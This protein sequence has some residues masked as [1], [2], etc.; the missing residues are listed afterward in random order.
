MRRPDGVLQRWWVALLLGPGCANAFGIFSPVSPDEN[1]TRMGDAALANV[2]RWTARSPTI[3]YAIAPDLC[4]ALHPAIPEAVNYFSSWTP[5]PSVNFS[6]C[7]RVHAIVHNAFRTWQNANPAL[8][9]VDVSNRCESQRLWT[10]LDPVNCVLS[11]LCQQLE[12][13]TDPG[14]RDYVKWVEKS[15]PLEQANPSEDT[16]SHRT[17]WDCERAD[18]VIGAFSQKRRQLGDQHARAR[19]LRSGIVN[20]RH[21]TAM[22]QM[23]PV[24]TDGAPQAG[25]QLGRAFLQFNAD[26]AYMDNGTELGK[27][28]KVENDVCDWIAEMSIAGVDMSSEIS[29]YFYLLLSLSLVCCCCLFAVCLRRLA[30][31]LLQGYDMNDDG[32]ISCEELTYVLDEFIGDLCF[33]CQCPE[34][35]GTQVTKL[36]GVL[37]MLEAFANINV[38]SMGTVIFTGISVFIIYAAE[39]NMCLQCWDFAAAAHHEVGHLLSLGHPEQATS[40]TITVARLN[41][42]SVDFTP[43]PSPPPPPFQAASLLNRPPQGPQPS[44]PTPPLSPPPPSSPPP[45]MPLPPAAPL[46]LGAIRDQRMTNPW[47]G[48]DQA[49]LA[50]TWTVRHANHPFG[51][52]LPRHLFNRGALAAYNDS[53]MREFEPFAKDTPLGPGRLRK[54]LSQDDLDGINFLYPPCDHG[55]LYGFSTPPPCVHERDWEYTAQRLFMAVLYISFFFII[56]LIALKLGSALTLRVEERCARQYFEQQARDMVMH[57]PASVVQTA[58]SFFAIFTRKQNKKKIEHA[59]AIRLQNRTR[60]FLAKKVARKKKLR[61]LDQTLAAHR[62][63][64]KLQAVVRGRKLRDEMGLPGSKKARMYAMRKKI[65]VHKTRND[66]TYAPPRKTWEAPSVRMRAAQVMLAGGRGGAQ[67]APNNSRCRST[68]AGGANGCTSLVSV[69]SGA[70]TTPPDLEAANGN[71]WP[72]AVTEM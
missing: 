18:V 2:Y 63:A 65:A 41:T 48:L 54:C 64:A 16:C 5:F 9:F 67:I 39:F 14:S 28:W 12:N 34:V 61:K 1:V 71:V 43:P 8:H 30:Y 55:L 59:M 13:Q 47:C 52:E 25:G 19:V 36:S 15:T 11:P 70:R 53:M 60:I 3:R 22:T 51:P 37:T 56:T 58:E 69:H 45:M 29:L 62:A 66:V 33:Q 42:S 68:G 32:K 57:G 35:H 40:T 46:T 20:D 23:R 31:F 27:C 21:G 4:E 6:S 26:H 17:C 24:G 38:V 72:S 7:E 10:P 49:Q 50:E 44:P